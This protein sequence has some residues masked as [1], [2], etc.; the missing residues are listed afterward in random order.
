M[1]LDPA[2]AEIRKVRHEISKEFDHNTKALL[3][4]YKE[5]ETEFGDRLISKRLGDLKRSGEEKI[6]LK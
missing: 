4:H 6:H 3:D 1:K 5:M 2:I